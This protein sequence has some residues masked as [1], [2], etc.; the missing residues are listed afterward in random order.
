MV[1]IGKKAG[2]PPG[3]QR[4]RLNAVAAPGLAPKDVLT[5]ASAEDTKVFH[6]SHLLGKISF[7]ISSRGYQA[8]ESVYSQGDLADAVFYLESGGVKL[9]VVSTSGKEAVVAVLPETSF[10]GE[11]CL[12]GQPLRVCTV[13]AIQ[14]ST[15]TRVAKSAM[16]R[17]LHEEPE[18]AERFL[19]HLLTRNIRMQS[20]LVDHLFN[21]SEKRLARLL[22]LMANFG[23]E[24]K[25]IP[26]VAKM[27]QET[28]AE[29][30]GTTRSRVS[31]F[32]NRFRDLGF[33][34]YGEGGMHVHSS[35]VS[36]V[37]HD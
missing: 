24:S 19:T 11:G 18:F 3:K 17:L 13:T 35:L 15:V 28:L 1:T 6:P 8:G 36:V 31:F 9:T 33:I 32:M 21:S 4:V 34:E 2:K 37:L 27:S 16:N 12:A 26:L 7:G 20:D 23:H 25:P 14:Q 10:F 5:P 30:I 22:L 29:M